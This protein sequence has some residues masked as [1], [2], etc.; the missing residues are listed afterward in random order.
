MSVILSITM[1]GTKCQYNVE[2]RSS[3]FSHGA[4][5]YLSKP[6]GINEYMTLKNKQQTKRQIDWGKIDNRVGEIKGNLSVNK[7]ES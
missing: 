6:E 3:Q 5:K 1:F 4:F 2:Q 7:T